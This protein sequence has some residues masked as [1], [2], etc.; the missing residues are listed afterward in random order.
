MKTLLTFTLTLA[1]F[2][3][4]AQDSISRHA[5]TSSFYAGVPFQQEHSTKDWYEPGYEIGITQSYSFRLKDRFFVSL[6][7]GINYQEYR[8]EPY[9]RTWTT[10]QYYPLLGLST[11]V[12]NVDDYERQTVGKY[13]RLRVPLLV[14]YMPAGKWTPYAKAGVTLDAQFNERTDDVYAETQ[15][16]LPYTEQSYFFLDRNEFMLSANLAGGIKYQTRTI[17]FLFGVSGQYGLTNFR[18]YFGKQA[19]L[20]GEVSI[21]KTIGHTKFPHQRAIKVED[22]KIGKK[23]YVYLEGL[24]TVVWASLNYERSLFQLGKNRFHARVGLSVDKSGSGIV[25]YPPIGL[26]WIY[27]RKHGLEVGSEFVQT[28]GGSRDSYWAAHLGYRYETNNNFLFRVNMTG[29]WAESTSK[30]FS[31]RPGLAFGYRF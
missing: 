5:F 14:E 8:S 13:T 12:Y 20:V 29:E 21:R 27:G 6:G 19:S 10:Y 2:A 26:T 22:K 15:T 4:F 7:V 24:G 28:L 16:S 17:E 30:Q 23:N 11:P 18:D 1:A 31:L 3:T 9:K 25:V